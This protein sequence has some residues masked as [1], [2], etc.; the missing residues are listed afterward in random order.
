MI[1]FFRNQDIIL[2]PFTLAKPQELNS[3]FNDIIIANEGD[4]T[5]PLIIPIVACDDNLSGSCTQK[6]Y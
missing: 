2:T 4:E 6:K 5:F 3:V 1:K